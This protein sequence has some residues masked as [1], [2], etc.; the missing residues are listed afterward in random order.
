MRVTL[1][2]NIHVSKHTLFLENEFAQAIAIDF[3]SHGQWHLSR[4]RWYS[5][6]LTRRN[7]LKYSFGHEILESL[8]VE[9]RAT[10][11]HSILEIGTKTILI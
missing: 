5:V 8:G 9:R 1:I 6:K 2:I 10:H 3:S 4:V 11:R 7:F